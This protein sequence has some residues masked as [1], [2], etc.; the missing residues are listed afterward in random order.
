MIAI[1][2]GRVKLKGGGYSNR[3]PPFGEAYLV[4]AVDVT[5][6]VIMDGKKFPTD[7]RN[8]VTPIS[9]VFKDCRAYYLRRKKELNEELKTLPLKGSI[10][11]KK[12]KGH[13]YYYLAYRSGDKVK[14][15]YLGKAEPVELRQQIEKRRWI[16][17]QL[18]KIEI[19][20]YALGAA[21]R[22]QRPGQAKRFA[23]LERDNF[24]CQYCGR[25]VREH[26]VVLVIDHITPRKRGGSDAIDNLITACADCNAGKSASLMK[27]LI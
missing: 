9:A 14:F 23:V 2:R 13:T 11:N 8:E 25:N 17:K 19:A 27:Q 5:Y 18:K 1:S 10:A 22:S 24:T 7:E 15:D 26:K 12:I 20:L 16:L 3:K 21:K 4:A 6:T